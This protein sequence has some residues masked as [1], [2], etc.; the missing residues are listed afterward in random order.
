L[1]A[2]VAP[3][4]LAPSFGVAELQTNAGV[5]SGEQGAK[6][7]VKTLVDAIRS[8]RPLGVAKNGSSA[9]RAHNERVVEQ[10]HQSLDINGLAERS[11]GSTWKGLAKREHEE[12]ISLLRDLFGTV[13]YPRSSQF[14]KD[15]KLEVD[16]VETKAATGIRP[17]RFVVHTSLTHPE[18]GLVEIDFVVSRVK[19]GLRIQDVV[20][21]EVSLALDI[22]SQM[23]KIIREKSYK[24]LKRRI[25]E[26]LKEEIKP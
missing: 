3:L 25:E 10:A 26:K 12:F 11:L 24:E 13:A 18:E 7:I 17:E 8:Y 6:A 14:F 9:D 19:D 5:Q 15:L 22:R 21:D 20:L 4:V 16:E 23:Q 2:F 1:G